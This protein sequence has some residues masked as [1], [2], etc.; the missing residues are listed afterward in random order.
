MCDS[1]NTYYLLCIVVHFAS[2]FFLL[3][4]LFAHL[5]IQKKRRWHKKKNAIWRTSI[6]SFHFFFFISYTAK[7]KKEDQE[8][9]IDGWRKSDETNCWL[10][11]VNGQ[12]CIGGLQAVAVTT[13][14]ANSISSS[15]WCIHPSV[16]LGQ[17]QRSDKKWRKKKKKPNIDI[18]LCQYF[19]LSF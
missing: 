18:W 6:I 12:R 3:L 11:D 2:F 16:S 14:T 13:T 19:F 17:H 7:K 5:N 10:S 4:P 15:R 8:V 9:G 1:R